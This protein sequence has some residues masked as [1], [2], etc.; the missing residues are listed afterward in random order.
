MPTA[1]IL[2]E[3][4]SAAVDGGLTSVGRVVV[5]DAPEDVPAA[6]AALLST[7]TPL[8]LVT[9]RLA[10]ARGIDPDPIHRDVEAYRLAADAA[11]SA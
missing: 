8:Q 2:S 9:E 6:V 5:P 4:Y 3:S 1:A 11:E 10:R 7:A